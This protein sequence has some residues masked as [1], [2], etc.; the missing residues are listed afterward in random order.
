MCGVGAC[1]RWGSQK[2][3]VLFKEV[4]GDKE[5]CTGIPKDV[6]CLMLERL[7]SGSLFGG[8]IKGLSVFGV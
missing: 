2:S 6:S 1:L 3:A 8:S 5:G 4:I 7:N